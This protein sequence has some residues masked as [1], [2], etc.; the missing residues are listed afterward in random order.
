MDSPDFSACT[1]CGLCVYNRTEGAQG[2]YDNGNSVWR[3]S[4]SDPTWKD[5]ACLAIAPYISNSDVRL[6][7][8][9]DGSYCPRTQDDVNETCCTNNQGQNVT[10]LGATLP[11]STTTSAEDPEQTP[12]SAPVS[13]SPSVTSIGQSVLTTSTS[14]ADVSPASST[15]SP[16]PRPSTG[17]GDSTSKTEKVAAIVGSIVG[18]ATLVSAL[19]FGINGW[20]KRKIGQSQL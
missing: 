10:E 20:K 11:A 2:P 14:S 16:T 13:A 3:D 8:C 19:V 9:A 4:C 12:T 15:T 6:N 17:G 18:V 7:Q 1:P 5:P